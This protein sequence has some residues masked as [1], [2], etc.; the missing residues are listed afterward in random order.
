M[1]KASAGS[2]LRGLNGTSAGQSSTGTFAVRPFVADPFATRVPVASR[3]AV[4][5]TRQL[6]AASGLT[7]DSGPGS[8]FNSFFSWQV[9][10][11]R[12]WGKPG[13]LVRPPR[14]AVL[15][16]PYFVDGPPSFGDDRGQAIYAL[17]AALAAESVHLYLCSTAMAFGELISLHARYAPVAATA[18]CTAFSEGSVAAGGGTAVTLSATAYLSG[19]AGGRVY[20]GYLGVDLSGA[21]AGDVRGGATTVGAYAVFDDAGA[22]ALL[23]DRIAADRAVISAVGQGFDR[24]TFRFWY[25]PEQVQLSSGPDVFMEPVAPAVVAAFASPYVVGRSAA[26]DAAG[27]ASAIVADILAFFAD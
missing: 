1:A 16:D 15:I 10:P 25:T 21:L 7:F 8:F 4:G 23:D 18:P 24:L 12:Y 5:W 14:T 3:V 20:F 11:E 17:R 9:E 6:L 26:H 13:T 2:I 19:F 22:V 27:M